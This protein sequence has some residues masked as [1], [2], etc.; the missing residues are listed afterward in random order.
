MIVEVR[1]ARVQYG[2]RPSMRLQL[3]MRNLVLPP[4]SSRAVSYA[5]LLFGVVEPIV[6]SFLLRNAEVIR[7]GGYSAA[8]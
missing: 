8:T 3:P 2:I 6:S 4:R 5:R 1:P 7:C